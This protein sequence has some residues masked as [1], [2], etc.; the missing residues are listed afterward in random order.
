MGL[1]WLQDVAT[2]PPQLERA[3]GSFRIHIPIAAVH[4]NS[5]FWQTDHNTNHN[6]SMLCMQAGV[7]CIHH[8]PWQM[9]KIA[10][11]LQWKYWIHWHSCVISIYG[12]CGIW[13]MILTR[14]SIGIFMVTFR[15]KLVANCERGAPQ[16]GSSTRPKSFHTCNAASALARHPQAFS[17]WR[18]TGRLFSI[19]RSVM[20]CR[21]KRTRK[22][23]RER[24]SS[25]VM[26]SPGDLSK[27]TNS[28]F[29]YAE[30]P[31]A[32][33]IPQSLAAQRWPF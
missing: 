28:T 17:G 7:I 20:K 8:K 9:L 12:Y 21:E 27:S 19:N 15:G 4:R 33:F 3:S 11:K 25:V 23:E 13:N 26:I 2:I 14:A 31:L 29:P 6:R 1:S 32:L 30:S 22:E 18:H 24:S 10:A 5:P 16:E